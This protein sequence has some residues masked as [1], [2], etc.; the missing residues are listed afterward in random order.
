MNLTQKLIRAHLVSGDLRPGEEIALRIDQTLTQDATGTLCYLQFEA[1][2]VP[3]VRTQLSVSYVDH[4][5][6]QA[7]A[8]NADD[9][10]YLQDVA[11][12]YGIYFS[13][14]GNGICHQVHLERF[15]IPGTT[16]LGTDSHTPTCGGMGVLAIGA[17]GLDVA[18][19]MA[20]SPYFLRMP[21]VLGVELRGRLQPGVTAKDVILELLRRL[22]VKGGVGRVLE[23]YGP[24][25]ES[26]EVPER[27]T[28]TNMGAELG[29]TTSI[30]PS[31]ARTLEFLKRQQRAHHFSEQ[32]ADA[33]ATYDETLQL[34]LSQLEPLIACPDS[35]DNVCAV[36]EVLGTPVQQVAIGSCT[37][38]SYSDLMTVA[39]MLKGRRVHP[40][41][42][43][44]I[45]PGSRQVLHML[46]RNGA[47]ADLIAA[48]ARILESACGPCAGMGQV[49]GSGAVSLRSFNRNFPG[50]SGGLDNRV[51][52]ASPAV[53]AAAAL[54]GEI[55][56]PREFATRR[57]RL[58][59][60]YLVDDSGILPPA[61]D[62]EGVVIRR[63]PN[64]KPLPTRGEL[65]ATLTGEV[66]LCL[67]DNISTD[68]ILPAGP[69]VLPLRSNVPAIAEY[70]FRYV[71][72]EFVARCRAKGG[73]FLVA[74][75]NYGQGSSR[76][77]AALC[78]MY[79]GVKAVIAKSFARIHRDNLINY[80]VLPLTLK[81]EAD[82]AAFAPGDRLEIGDVRRLLATGA[83]G[84]P[85]V[86]QSRQVVVE[87]LLEVTPRQRQILLAGGLLRFVAKE[88]RA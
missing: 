71:D 27:A 46:A 25:V 7:D 8:R 53:C 39:A 63:G 77:H 66:L 75:H 13:R 22:T 84:I 20:G 50:R 51:Y 19:A 56:D 83:T 30:F 76:E 26:L 44:V 9:H 41:V 3:R 11:A 38:S 33:D 59:A 23:Y 70:V 85:V 73:G 69:Q 64:I 49:P 54:A 55:A 36:R 21:K 60:K 40:H 68:H 57:I 82:Y 34:D 47:L 18:I 31:D 29:A 58:P 5:M 15:A 12:K 6:L 1:I 28:I 62:P 65:E 43:L 45:A 37:N 88:S 74:G 79:L 10:A 80:A 4:N 32:R 61:A 17:G 72:P 52:L 16:L 24:G 35:P 48:G 78:P 14:P 42:S 2:G 86:N 67:G 81:H 87:T